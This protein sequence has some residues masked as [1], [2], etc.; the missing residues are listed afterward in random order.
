MSSNLAEASKYVEAAE[1]ML[2]GESLSILNKRID[3]SLEHM[4]KAI[5]IL[6]KMSTEIQADIAKAKNE[7][8]EIS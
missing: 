6:W 4:D 1:K 5:S 8:K 3:E 2:S 7:K